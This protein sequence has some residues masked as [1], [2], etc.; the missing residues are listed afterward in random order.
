MARNCQSSE[1]WASA[2]GATDANPATN[3]MTSMDFGFIVQSPVMRSLV[4]ITASP[5]ANP[6]S[7]PPHP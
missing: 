2:P 4:S 3:A 5:P 7:S 6:L 1:I